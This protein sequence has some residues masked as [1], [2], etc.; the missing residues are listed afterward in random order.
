MA[1]FFWLGFSSVIIVWSAALAPALADRRELR[2]L[3]DS[4]A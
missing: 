2:R 1:I 3:T 4:A